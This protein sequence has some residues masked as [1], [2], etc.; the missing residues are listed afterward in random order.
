MVPGFIEELR[1][2]VKAAR[3]STRQVVLELTE[4]E[5]FEDLSAA[6][7]VVARLRDYG[8]SV[9]IDDVGVGNS[10]LSHIQKLGAN[11]LKVDKFFVDSICRDVTAATVVE[12]LVRLASELK[13]SVVAEGIEDHEQL[14]ALI[15]CGIEQG[16]GFVVSPP[17]PVSE[18]IDF[19]DHYLLWTSDNINQRAINQRAVNAV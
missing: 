16:Q 11:I 9:A 13:M 17:L 6:A 7:V 2:I 5:E 1:Q 8:F 18:F 12:M 19:H 10:G 4:R 14:V 3:V 15:A